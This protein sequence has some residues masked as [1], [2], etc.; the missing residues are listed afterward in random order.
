MTEEFE[1][2]LL[3]AREALLADPA[4]AAAHARVGAL[5][6]AL[7][8]P[9]EAL[10]HLE[11]SL[12]LDPDRAETLNN[13]GAVHRAKGDPASAC[14]AF[15]RALAL[16]PDY[17]DARQNLKAARAELG[18]ERARAGHALVEA[19]D[20][21]AAAAE[22]EA[23]IRLAPER[24]DY[25]QFLFEADPEAI[26]PFLAALE[27]LPPGIETDFAAG[28]IYAY[29]GER[30]R[31]FARLIRAN[32][33]ARASRE[34]D[35]AS[36]LRSFEEIAEVFTAA[37][38]RQRAGAGYP[39]IG[40]VFI[41]GMPRSGTTL[42]EQ[43]LAA[44]PHVYAAGE[45]PLFDTIATSMLG[46]GPAIAYALGERYARELAALAP[47]G[48][49]RITDKV[50][51]NFR[52]AGLI[53]LALPYAKLIH[54]RR[55]PLDTCLSCFSTNFAEGAIPYAYDLGELGRYYRG[56]ARL[57]EHWRSALPEGAMLE[58][59]YRDVV[60]D[61]ETQ[62]RRVVAFCGLE[63]DDRCLEFYAAK[64]PVQTASA[65]QV[66]RPI[67]RSSLGTARG[68]EALLAPLVDALSGE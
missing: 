28:K 47:P 49:R 1:S 19:G 18:A 58:V 11:R 53:H 35:E 62:A 22:F 27:G 29:R 16:H 3:R 36:T 20:I 61:L 40:P 63:W 57:M 64:R 60:G 12:A 38:L 26:G 51:A 6:A 13:L 45:T 37:Y 56:Y 15:E 25:Y 10:A 43:I 52:Y 59:D 33:A 5:L 23:A 55:D 32:V 44:H 48:A 67:Y 14:A 42:I 2:A 4:S 21:R 8:R 65:V 66:R 68:Y 24:G 34:Y 46:D 54:A 7:Y 50:P 30:E 31:S 39:G 9:D 17:A 41:F